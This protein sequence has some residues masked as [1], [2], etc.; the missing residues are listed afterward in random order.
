MMN[1][2]L[3]TLDQLTGGIFGAIT[4]SERTA[5]VK[6]WLNSNPSADLMQAVYKEL[7]SRD[8]G[9]ARP[10]RERLDDLRKEKSQDVL[11]AE[12][13]E[14]AVLLLNLVKLNIAD[15]MAWQRDAAKAGAPL[16]KEPLADLRQKLSEKI[17][18]IEQLQHEISVL[19]ESSS[20]FILRLETLST[21]PF[22]EALTQ[23]ETLER[24]LADWQKKS[25]SLQTMEDWRHVD[26]NLV[27]QLQNS[28]TQLLAIWGAFD[29]VMAQAK[30]AR[31][32]ADA[33]LPSVPVWADE[34]KFLREQTSGASKEAV[35]SHKPKIDAEQRW[36][37]DQ[38][39]QVLVDQANALVEKPNVG[40]KQQDAIR[41]LREQWK[42]ADQGNA[43]NH[44]LWKL[45]DEA[46]NTAHKVVEQW[47]E[48]SKAKATAVIEQRVALIAELKA[49]GEA[50][51]VK[52][53]S[54]KPDWKAMI[55]GLH[56]FGER[57]REAGHLNER[58]FDA[59]QT[60][61]KTAL[62]EAAKPLDAAQKISI[63][64]RQA[65]IA[66]AKVMAAALDWGVNDVR[67]LQH[68]WQIDAQAVPLERKQEQKLWDAFKAVIDGAFAQKDE[69]RKAAKEA[70]IANLSEHDKAVLEA[71]K[72]LE[73][74]NA[75]GEVGK[76]HSAM[77]ALQ[78]ALR[79]QAAQVAEAATSTEAA[80]TEAV[81]TPKPAKPLIAMRS[82][83][84]KSAKAPEPARGKGREVGK[85]AGR[86]GQGVGDM[87]A[88]EPR[89]ERLPRLS[90]EAFHMQR[91]AI[92][93]A[94]FALK[95]LQIQAHGEVVTTIM[96]AWKERQADQLPALQA[97]GKA[98]NAAVRV[99]WAKALQ[100]TAGAESGVSLLRLEMATGMP[101]PADFL[102]DRRALQLQLLTKRNDPAPA[103]TWGADV[104]KVLE[105]AYSDDAAKRLQANLKALLK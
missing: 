92:E 68:E 47:L 23:R 6:D 15:A 56:Q 30:T 50:H 101:T 94:E 69:L 11:A 25:A 103:Q 72:T 89:P 102:N 81:P 33:P 93:Q 48:E 104:A 84:R 61:W 9:A 14:K 53:T 77:T 79:G 41:Q 71:S 75:S 57:W 13:A 52:A 87:Q 95:K 32:N 22:V 51:A 90:D 60:N 59:M 65:L 26:A 17:N 46:C 98:V 39:R 43:P 42:A 55:R 37:T 20:L 4:S 44:S 2:D 70:H 82:D 38:L 91:K 8:K 63:A 88:R 66:R 74:A 83:D 76:I 62:K 35:S 67:H 3:P 5:R 73:A 99:Q 16:S 28:Q 80:P 96:N 24:D 40:R 29:G 64:N 78:V 10:L 36:R 1:F 54:G 100:A 49:W 21:K 97:L 34:I 19:R 27:P 85:T 18:K 31:D 45:F 58:D 7:S 105:G 12:W 86:M